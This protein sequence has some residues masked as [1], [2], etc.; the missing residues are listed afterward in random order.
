MS[1]IARHWYFALTNPSTTTNTIV[2]NERVRYAVWQIERADFEG[3]GGLVL[4]GYVEMKTSVRTPRALVRGAEFTQCTCD[5][6]DARARCTN[7]DYR[8]DGPWEHGEWNRPQGRRSDLLSKTTE[9]S[10]GSTVSDA[11]A[12]VSRSSQVSQEQ[13]Q[14][15]PQPQPQASLAD[16]LEL[17]QTIV[18]DREVVT[19][20]APTIVNTYI[21]NGTVNNNHT[22][23]SNT[24][25]N[26]IINDLRCEDL[27]QFPEDRIKE[28][29]LQ[30]RSGFLTFVRESRFNP[31]IPQNRNLRLVSKKQNLAVVKRNGEW[32]RGSIAQSIEEV[33]D[34]SK[35]QFLKPLD[36]PTYMGHLMEQEPPVIDWCQKVMA[37][38]PCEW[39]PIKNTVRGELE[40]A[41]NTERSAGK[42]ATLPAAAFDAA[43]PVPC[44]SRAGV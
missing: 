23:V 17:L 35:A 25:A 7:K 28:L 16:I 18:R 29:I 19:P 10:G 33:L 12:E 40:R 43:L 22:I 32:K 24:T 15:Q 42:Q 6:E 11:P 44:L 30:T 27:S 31:D 38:K 9:S 37:K 39:R 4:R 14:P 41:Y 36:D 26:I 21:N 8:V 20:A 5:R 13:T 1:G 34:A 2:W 3:G